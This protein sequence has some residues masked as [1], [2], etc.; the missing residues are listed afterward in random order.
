M[1]TASALPP[2]IDLFLSTAFPIAAA[3]WVVWQF[4]IRR[5]AVPGAEL[6]IDVEFVSRQDHS[7]VIEVVATLTNQSLVRH[8]YKNF[9]LSVRYLLPED[10]LRD[11]GEKINHQLLCTRTIDERIG[12]ARRYFANSTYI[13]PKLTFRHSYVTFVPVEATVIWVQ[14]NLQFPGR[15]RWYDWKPVMET[16][17]LQ[18]VFGV[19]QVN[20][21]MH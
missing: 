16:K 11:G 12:G 7:W 13:D 4:L 9:R 8:W 15:R 14:C 17:N 1:N 2:A 6:S 21:A 5:E 19:P 3:V 20:A 10:S 18:R